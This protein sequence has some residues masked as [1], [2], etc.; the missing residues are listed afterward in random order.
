LQLHPVQSGH[1]FV[2]GGG[3]LWWVDF[4]VASALKDVADLHMVS[5]LSVFEVTS[6]TCWQMCFFIVMANVCFI[7]D[8]TDS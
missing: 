6:V 7:F 4:S 2:H 5:V 3:I 8:L 1:G